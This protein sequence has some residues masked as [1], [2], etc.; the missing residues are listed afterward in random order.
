MAVIAKVAVQAATYAIDKPY[1]YLVP[2]E[3][4]GTLEPGM[5][6]L[7]P[8]GGAGQAAEGGPIPAG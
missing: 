6:V 3:L 8:F 7:V 1:D 5:R 4:E 2:P